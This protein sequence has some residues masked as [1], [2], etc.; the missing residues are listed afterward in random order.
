MA[1][2]SAMGAYFS[3][4]DYPISDLTRHNWVPIPEVY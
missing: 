2:P 4:F 1:N 3:G